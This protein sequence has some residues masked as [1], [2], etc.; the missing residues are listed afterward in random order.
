MGNQNTKKVKIEM[1]LL[2]LQEY[3]YNEDIY[4]LSVDEH[5]FIY[6]NKDKFKFKDEFFLVC[7]NRMYYDRV[8]KECELKRKKLREQHTPKREETSCD[9]YSG[10]ISGFY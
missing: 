1:D 7:F 9:W 6:D 4:G 8:I 2:K 3:L 5:K 10:G